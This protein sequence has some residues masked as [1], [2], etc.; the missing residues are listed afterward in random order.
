M[1]KVIG[2]SALA[3]LMVLASGTANAFECKVKE[4]SM[5]GPGGFPER[6]L[7]MI[8]PYGPGGGSG[9]PAEGCGVPGMFLV[10]AVLIVLW[11]CGGSGSPA[12]GSGGPVMW[13]K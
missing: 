4:A 1:K 6:A 3:G 13:F 9:C 10:V 8:V 12:G 11:S 5:A 7:S 2:L